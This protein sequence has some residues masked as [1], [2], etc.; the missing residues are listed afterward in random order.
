MATAVHVV[1]A[2]VAENKTMKLTKEQLKRI[3]KEEL[4]ATLLEKP[5]G[6]NSERVKLVTQMTAVTKELLE[7]E[8]NTVYYYLTSSWTGNNY[9]SLISMLKNPD[10]FATENEFRYFMKAILE[11]EEHVKTL[12]EFGN[13]KKVSLNI[14]NAL[15]TAGQSYI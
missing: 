4:Q 9:K 1:N 5:D 6:E 15:K 8:I 14:I 11:L 7:D 3:I 2:N 13:A 12:E 10:N